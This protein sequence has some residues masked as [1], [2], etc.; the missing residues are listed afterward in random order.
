MRRT[1]VSITL[2]AAAIASTACSST[3]DPTAPF[4]PAAPVTVAAK[5]APDTLQLTSG[6]KCRVPRATYSTIAVGETYSCDRA[7]TQTT[8]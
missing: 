3:N 8:P 2:A 6:A 5:I 1:L 4:T 7:P